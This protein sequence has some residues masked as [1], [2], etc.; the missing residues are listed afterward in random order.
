MHVGSGPQK[1]SLSISCIIGGLVVN[2]QGILRLEGLNVL[3]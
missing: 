2:D 1:A 3:A